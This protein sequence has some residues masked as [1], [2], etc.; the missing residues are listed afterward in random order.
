MPSTASGPG[1]MVLGPDGNLWFTELGAPYVGCIAVP[2]GAITQYLLP[3]PAT[4]S[5]DIVVGPDGALWFTEPSTT[6][7][8]WIGRITT[9]GSGQITQFPVPTP[10]ASVYGITVGPDGNIWFTEW[11]TKM[12]GRL[13][14]SNR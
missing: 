6:G 1:N 5:T 4:Q 13:T 2:S 10:A 9:T 7:T 14:I 3:D 11:G 8:N 12:I